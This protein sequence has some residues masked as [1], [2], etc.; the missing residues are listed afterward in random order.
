M[1]WYPSTDSKPIAFRPSD[2]GVH[3][4]ENRFNRPYPTTPNSPMPASS[5]LG[6][7]PLSPTY[8]VPVGAE[9][10][11]RADFLHVMLR[12]ALGA[13]HLAP[14]TAPSYILDVACG[15]GRWVRE[16]AEEFPSARVVGL[17]IAVPAES[18]PA[19]SGAF[20]ASGQP[21]T[22]AFVQHNV[23]E[24]FTFVPAS[25]DLTHMRQ[26]ISILP[27]AAWPQVV[28]EMVRVTA[29]GGWVELVEGDLLRNG[30]PALEMIQR[31]A[32]Q[33]MLPHGLDPRISVQLADLLNTLSL[34][35]VQ[36]HTIELPIGPHGGRFGELMGADFLA[37]VEGMR[38]HV[39][40]ARLATSEGFTQVQRA[41]QEE[42]NNW[43]YTQPFYVVYGKR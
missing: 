22:Y 37:R 36:T 39:I 9:V 34:T 33:I 6:R 16:M 23:L 27:V 18:S 43:E 28:G 19:T 15:S 10:V 2:S 20:A 5:T 41:L 17:D 8:T 42:M 40:A 32:L 1:S 3:S 29:F 4:G 31:W 14:A 7:M 12:A 30:G 25:F 38:A 35:D 21:P 13:N 11:A 24:P 26:M